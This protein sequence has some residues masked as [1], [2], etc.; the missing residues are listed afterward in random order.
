[1][2]YTGCGQLHS[3]LTL[4]MSSYSADYS[5]ALFICSAALSGIGD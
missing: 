2:V 3:A 1:M 4:R 5:E